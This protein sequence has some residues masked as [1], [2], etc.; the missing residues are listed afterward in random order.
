MLGRLH[1]RCLA[2]ALYLVGSV[3]ASASPQNTPR[4]ESTEASKTQVLLSRLPLEFEPASH[5]PDSFLTRSGSVLIGLSTTRMDFQV[6]IG[7]GSHLAIT[8]D[9]AN[10]AANVS[11]T[12]RTAAESNYLVGN[13]ASSWRTHVPHYDRLTYANVYSG[14]NLTLYGNGQHLEHDFIVKPGADWT[15][16]QLGYEGARSLSLDRKGNL[17][18]HMEGSEVVMRA[19]FIYQMDHGRRRQRSGR[20]VIRGRQQVGFSV[21]GVDRSAALVIDPVLDFSTYLANLSVYVDGVA[22]DPSGNTYIVGETFSSAF[23]VTA[24]VAQPVCKSCPNTGDIFV[25]KLNSAGTAQ[26]YSTYIGGNDDDQPDAIAVDTNGNAVVTGF[27]SS[28]D[29]PLKNPITSGTATTYDGF[30]TSLTPDGSS[31]NFSSRLGGSSSAGTSANT[32]PGA[33]T[34]DSHGNVYVSGTTES[35]YL[36]VTSGALNAGVPSYANPYIFL[37]KLQLNGS[38]TFGAMVGNPGAASGGVGTTGLAI[39]S[40]GDIYMGGTVGQDSTSTGTATPWPTTPNA[41]QTQLI[42]PNQ[43]APFA[44][45]VAADGSKLIYSTLLGSGHANT[46]TVDAKDE[47][48]LAGSAGYSFP[49]VAGGYS[50]VSAPSFIAKLSADGTT[51]S[52]SSFF[53]SS[54]SSIVSMTMDAAGNLWLVGSAYGG[55]PLVQPLQSQSGPG[56]TGYVAELDPLLQTL[57]FSTFFN[58]PSGSTQMAGVAADAQSRIHIAGTAPDDLPTTSGAFL[59]SVTPP[60]PNYVYNYGFAAV[61]DANGASPAICTGTSISPTAQVGSSA[62]GSFQL[63]NCGSAA[64]VISA[65]KL[66][67]AQFS[68]PSPAPCVES[69]AIGASCTIDYTFSP[70]VAGIASGTILITSNAPTP[71]YSANISGFGTA[72]QISVVSS[73][74]TFPTQVTGVPGVNAVA[75]IAN[76][77]TAALVIDTAKTTITSPFSIVSTTCGSPVPPPAPSDSGCTYTLS[78]QP[79][80]VGTNTGTLTIFSNDPVTPKVTIAL[81]GTELAAYSGPTINTLSPSAIQLDSPATHIF[82][83]G[84]NFFPASYIVVGGEPLP[85]TFADSSQLS[86]TIDASLLTS[87]GE[88]PVSVVNPS[89][90]GASASVP[91][92]V[93]RALSLSANSLIYE[94]V[95]KLLYISVASTATIDPNTVVPI[96][97]LTGIAGT[98]IAVGDDPGKLAVASDGSSLYVGINGDHTLERINLSKQAVDRTFP[99]PI[100]SFAGMTTV[101]DIHVVPGSPQSVVVSLSR[102]ASPAEAGAALYNDSGVVSFVPNDYESNYYSIDSFAFTSSSSNYYAF[103]FANTFFGVTQVSSSALTPVT[104]GFSCCDETTG[105]LVASDGTSLYTNS[106]EVWNPV[107]RTLIGTLTPSPATYPLGQFFYEASVV[108]DSGTSRVF[109]LDDFANGDSIYAFNSASLSPTGVISVPEQN[110][111]E[112]SDLVRWGAD[113]FAFRVK[114]VTGN[115]AITDQIV[116]L[117][118]S[119]AQTSAGSTPT[120]SKLTPASAASGSPTLTLSLAG[121]GFI[122]GSTVLWNGTARETTFV[123]TSNLTAL[124]PLTDLAQAGTAQITVSNPGGTS[125]ALTFTITGP[126]I[127]LSTQSLNFGGQPVGVAS[128][129]LLITVTNAGQSTV[130]LASLLYPITGTNSSD[131]SASTSCGSS[132]TAGAQCSIS[133]VFKPTAASAESATLTFS[134]SGTPAQTVSLSGTGVAADF[135]VVA[136]GSASATISA[137]QSAA[138]SLTFTPV[139]GFTGTVSLACSDLPDGVACH[140]T[141]AS[142]SLASTSATT[143]AISV[144]TQAAT[145]AA[146][147]YPRRNGGHL[148]T[149]VFAAF[150]FLGATFWARRR[151]FDR[152]A[153]ALCS[154]LLSV[155]C[156]SLV[157]GLAGCSSSAN[158]TKTV[159]GTPSGTYM[160]TVTSTSGTTSHTTTLTLIVQ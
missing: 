60:P 117:R 157:T 41:Y 77:G 149:Q 42:S 133:L 142:A 87:V 45:K 66:T 14:V 126:N 62:Q 22:T 134:V 109:F 152:R 1:I 122:A 110:Y 50:S 78:Y 49:I 97:P 3:G 5:R 121:S 6:G 39:D 7:S 8:L 132:L 106:G 72:P 28:S 58:G 135:S 25:T 70:T 119:L 101:Q 46:M 108:P 43:N 29:Y 158:T 114:D 51:L 12:E 23:P 16:I 85:T 98:P 13:D 79:T 103:P 147:S 104:S 48:L 93:F 65:L 115:N 86:A 73:Q 148:P 9:H 125:T 36:P 4:P 151:R 160:F 139:G 11:A 116:I 63:T 40:S 123:S 15:R 57:L 150:I 120:L 118:S 88:L 155:C 75:L 91:L 154:M 112:A 27:T 34:T 159:S 52:Y 26:V 146:M 76:V 102:P 37:T 38:L 113:G 59:T 140:F 81:S 2:F 80:A 20:Y 56:N 127:T 100:D 89:P 44:T 107:T 31:F 55:L 131:F 69:L 61:I 68:L 64:L 105:S 90:G 141:P 19:P 47:I 35:P 124:V 53:S 95:S 74:V 138:Y 143:V 54:A 21:D 67:S 144:S 92:P 32:Y 145:T 136:G 94:P 129:P 71:S 130:P 83:Q 17:H 111:P 96:D 82:V 156:L 30:V 99:L 18:V 128:T 24:G 10:S 137:G 33:V 84:S 153:L